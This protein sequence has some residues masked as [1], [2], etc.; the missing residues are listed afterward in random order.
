M[1]PLL[2][3]NT[4]VAPET[5][6]LFLSTTTAEMVAEVGVVTV[7]VGGVP[8]ISLFEA[9]CGADVARLIDAAVGVVVVVV[10]PVRVLPPPPH[11]ANPSAN[12]ALAA[13]YLKIFMSLTPKLYARRD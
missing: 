13:R 2:A 8:V 6:L 11:A 3:A 7:V 1:T 5:A 4:T 9:I 10:L 12:N